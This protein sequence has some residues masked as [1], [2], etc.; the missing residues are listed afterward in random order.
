L[1]LK[2]PQETQHLASLQG[3]ISMKTVA[4]VTSQD[5]A[6]LTPGD[7]LLAEAFQDAG[8]RVTPTVW[9]DP[10][11]RWKRFDLILIRSPWDYYHEIEAFQEWLTE[12][13]GAFVLNPIPLVRW[14][15]RKNYLA[16]LAAWGVPIVPTIFLEQGQ[17]TSLALA[18]E[19]RGW[20]E[21]VVK[22]QISAGAFETWP[23]TL[24][25]AP[26]QQKKFEA[27]LTERPLLIQPL[28]SEIRQFG[29]WSL[30]FFAGEFS[31]AVLKRPSPGDFRV[32]TEFGGSAQR[33]EP[34]EVLLDVAVRAITAAGRVSPWLYARVDLV[35]T[36]RGPLL[37]ELELIEPEL[38]FGLAS[39]AAERFVTCLFASATT[40]QPPSSNA[41]AEETPST[42]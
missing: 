37:M 40:Y 38:F 20:Q 33:A 13:E 11:V 30:I 12:R 17:P 14:N 27:S 28:L 35:E 34:S 41:D 4:F 39:G 25:Q 31:H 42:E 3:I 18:L 29:E 9:S 5:L 21:A 1:C 24:Q 6:D 2:H 26:T 19:E 8:M 22:P 32:Q 7:T 23:C 15:L 36:T 10:S 16:Q